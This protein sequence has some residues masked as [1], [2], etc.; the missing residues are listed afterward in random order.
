MEHL[1]IVEQLSGPEGRVFAPQVL[2]NRDWRYC[3]QKNLTES[4]ISTNLHPFNLWSQLY[5]E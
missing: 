1:P 5:H 3:D 2:K 4:F